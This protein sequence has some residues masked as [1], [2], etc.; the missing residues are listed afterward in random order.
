MYVMTNAEAIE[1][2]TGC[3]GPNVIWCERDPS[4][5]VAIPQA[6]SDPQHMREGD[7]HANTKGPL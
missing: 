5:F 6:K 1:Y 7:I 4:D 2:V 3:I